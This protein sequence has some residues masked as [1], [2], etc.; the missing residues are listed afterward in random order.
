MAYN[1]DLPVDNTVDIRENFR[2]LKEDKIV[3]AATTIKLETARAINSVLFD[4]TADI[5]ITQVNG[6]DIATTDKIPTSLP[7][8]GGDAD[9]VDGK[10]AVDFAPAGYV[11]PNATE[12]LD[13]SMS[14]ADKAKLDG[15]EAGA[16]VNQNA[17]SNVVVNGTTIHA[18]SQTDTIELAGGTNIA[19]NADA[20][21]EKVTIAVT[22]KVASAA[23]ADTA[24]NAAYATSAG[25]AD[26]LDGHHWSEVQTAIT[27]NSFDAGHSFNT[28][29]YQKLASGLIIQW[30][31]YTTSVGGT[32]YRSFPIPFPNAALSISNS[33]QYGQSICNVIN[34]STYSISSGSDSLIGTFTAIGY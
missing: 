11:P 13:G 15:I 6:K 8:N 20:A 12:T 14:A 23:Q 18:D 21:S 22:G 33:W 9:T 7:A 1:Q 26:T 30:G 27:A 17:F 3:A 29:G 34:R 25:N 16:Q 10:H 28:N 5:T 24:T 2:A 4:G 31:S 19:L 32:E